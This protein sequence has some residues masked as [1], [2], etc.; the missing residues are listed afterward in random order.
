M[1]QVDK[2]KMIFN[3]HHRAEQDSQAIA[4]RQAL[5]AKVLADAEAEEEQDEVEAVAK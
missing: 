1:E 3:V 4:R 5:K 2:S